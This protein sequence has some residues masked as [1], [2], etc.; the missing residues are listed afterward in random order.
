MPTA[1]TNRPTLNFDAAEPAVATDANASALFPQQ[2]VY[3]RTPSRK[4][5]NNL[6]LLVGVPVVAVV[7]GGL[8]W[9]MTAN[10]NEAPTDQRS[11]QTAA[12]ESPAPLK[13]PL[14]PEATPSPVPRPTEV[15]A[16]ETPA[17]AP[18][19][20]ASTP[21]AAP[22][23]ATARRAAPTEASAPDAASASAE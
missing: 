17:P 3:A 14:P 10:R 22:V 13:A 6:P 23:R 16:N 11:L 2:P 21:R 9:A 8:I 4:A 1:Y 15:A 18:V 12:A 20:R 19:A 7:A 5:S